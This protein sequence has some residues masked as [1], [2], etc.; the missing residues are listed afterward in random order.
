MTIVWTVRRRVPC[1]DFRP[2]TRHVPKCDHVGGRWWRHGHHLSDGSPWGDADRRC[3]HRYLRSCPQNHGI[4]KNLLDF[5][6]YWTNRVSTTAMIPLAA[7]FNRLSPWKKGHPMIDILLIGT[8]VFVFA[9]V[10]MIFP[11]PTA[12]SSH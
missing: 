10:L 6:S 7:R 1:R 5:S 11:P 4:P 2:R 12:T 8:T 3:P 9:V